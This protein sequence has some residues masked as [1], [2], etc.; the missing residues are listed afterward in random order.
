MSTILIADDE[1]RIR[2]YLA[3]GVDRCILGTIA[4]KDIEFT[5]RMARPYGPRIAVGV[6][7]K[8]G[9]VAVNGWKVHTP[10]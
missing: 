6:D 5:R 8:D 4:V 2:R 9:F 10:E 1:A 3:L 7:M